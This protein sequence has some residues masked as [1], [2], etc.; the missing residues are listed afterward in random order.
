MPNPWCLVIFVSVSVLVAAPTIN[1]Q[2]VI[3]VT[4]QDHHIAPSF[5]ELYR[6]G[7]LDGESW[8]LLSRVKRVGFDARGNLYIFDDGGSRLFPKL[9]ILVF[10]ADGAFVRE[11]GTQGEGPGEFRKPSTYAV[12]RDGTTVVGDDALRAYHVFDESGNFVRMVRKGDV[13]SSSD[14]G[15]ATV[16]GLVTMPIHA[17][18]RGGAVYTITGEATFTG[19]SQQTRYNL[20]TIERHGLEGEDARIQTVVEA[21]KPPRTM[22]EE[23]FRISLP[24]TLEP[25]LLMGLL[26]DG[27]IVYSDSSA[28][29]LNVV[30]ADGSGTVR[31]ITRPFRPRPVT[32]RIE[33]EYKRKKEQLEAEGKGLPGRT[34]LTAS[35]ESHGEGVG[36]N[37]ALVDATFGMANE[38]SKIQPFYSEIPVL[39]KMRTTWEGRIWVMRQ[40]EELLEEGPIDVLNS[41]GEY[42]GTYSAGTTAMPSAFG[43]RGLAAFI[44]I[45]EQDV[46]SVVVRRLPIDVR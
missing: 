1:A 41:D 13:E 40:H 27:A 35:L 7:V 22:P 28:Y 37:P 30:V 16:V 25:Q 6:I 8:E 10:A 36:S 32:S 9:R 20:R 3:E 46:R 23:L 14:G 19:L 38:F 2:E 29:A 39:M 17:D 42:V 24:R 4:G 43:P 18:P 34:R 5:E 26:P 45:D 21:W 12:L 11:F 31:T 33:R 15:E 44:E